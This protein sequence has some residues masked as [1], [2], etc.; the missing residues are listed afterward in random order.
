MRL[1]TSSLYSALSLMSGGSPREWGADILR[2]EGTLGEELV[3]VWV[4]EVT[5]D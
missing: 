2:L 4:G 3:A 5:G 1:L